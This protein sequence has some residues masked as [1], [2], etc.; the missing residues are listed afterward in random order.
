[1]LTFAV[2]LKILLDLICSL[3]MSKNMKWQIPEQH[4]VV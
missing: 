2:S 4:N 1:M 3:E